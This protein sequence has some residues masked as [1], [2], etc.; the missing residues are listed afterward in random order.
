MS[1]S[2]HAQTADHEFEGGSVTLLGAVH[3]VTGAMTMV[4]LG[5]QNVLVDCGVAQGEEARRWRMPRDARRADAVILTHG[6]NDHVGS[7][8]LLIEE[9]YDGPIYGT[10]STL[11]LAA[12]VLAD[13]LRLQSFS[14]DEIERF[15]RRFRRLWRPTRYAP[16]ADAAG[17]RLGRGE[18][19]FRLHEAATSWDRRASSSTPTATG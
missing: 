14:S 2:F 12:L 16:A 15:S 8:P 13:G 18:T 11:E 9:G 7:V 5:G 4:N 1:P 6:H 17:E 10:R 3:A 19:R